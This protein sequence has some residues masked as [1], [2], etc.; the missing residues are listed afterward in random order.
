MASLAEPTAF[1]RSTSALA[2]EPP[3]PRPLLGSVMDAVVA[4]LTPSRALVLALTLT[5]LDALGDAATGA[6][7]PT[8]LF[9]LV[10]IGLAVWFRGAWAGYFMAALATG[11]SVVGDVLAGARPLRPMTMAWNNTMDLLLLALFVW[12]FAMLKGR[13]EI[14]AR[15]RHE[16]LDQLRHSERLNTVGK[17]ASGVAHEL[18]T[19]L[20][21]ISGRAQLIT[22]G[23]VEPEP[24]RKHAAIIAQQADRMAVIIRGLLDFAR[25]GGT[26]KSLEPLHELCS[27]TAALLR[28]LATRIGA[29]IVVRGEPIQALVNRPEL[30]QVLTNLITNALQA[31]SSGGTVEITTG[32]EVIAAPGGSPRKSLSCAVIRVSDDGDG[33]APEVLPRIFDPFF[34]TKDVGHGTGLGL[35][36]SYGI[37]RDHGGWIRV[38][39]RVGAGTTFAVHLPQ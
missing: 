34:T 25:R 7:T 14:E 15:L 21:V 16:T 26:E 35:S 33:I 13:L 12:L 1:R 23:K 2:S 9:Y 18:G 17:L 8:A 5:L 19:P 30:Q 4:R 37:V 10:P 3:P 24:V 38:N 36:V 28:P 20:N 22:T 31:M 29:E 6:E 32:A 39:S 11:L 27:E